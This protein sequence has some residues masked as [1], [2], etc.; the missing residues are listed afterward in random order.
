V[1][2]LLVLGAL[3][4][5]DG[6]Q[7]RSIS[8]RR[9]AEE[10]Y[11]QGLTQLEAGNYELA[12]AEFEEAMRYDSDL[13]DLQSRLQ[14]AKNMAG[15]QVTPTSETRQDAAALLYRQAVPHYESGNLAQA[16][17]ILEELRGLDADYQR[18][19]VKTMLLQAHRHLAQSAV[20]ENRLE[21]AVREFEAVL[22]LK[23]D[24]KET[25]DQLN[26]LDLY[27][28]ALQH[29]EGD[30]PSAIQALTDLYALAPDYKDV[31]A[32]LHN[33]HAFYA[34]EF[35]S[36]GDW[37]Q[38]AEEYGAAAEVF[39]LEATVDQRDDAAIQC[40]ATLEAPT[41][42]PALRVTP[43]PT[44]VSAAVAA[45]PIPRPTSV[46]GSGSKTSRGTGRIA[47]A[48]YD[49]VKQKH[50]LYILD[51]AQGGAQLVRNR[52]SQADF[53]P[54]GS[55]AGNAQGGTQRLVFRNH[56]PSHLGLGLLSPSTGEIVDLTAHVEDSNPAWSPDGQQILFAS[57]KHGDRKWRI[58]V[59]SP[60]AVRGE[61]EEW[62][63][64][65]MPAW[66]PDNTQVAYHGCDVRGDNCGVWIMKSGGFDPVRL[67]TDPS[68]TAPN[69]SPDGSQIAFISARSGNWE[70]YRV[71]MGTGEEFRLTDNPAVDVAPTWSP[72]GGQLAFLS[73]RG[74][75][76]AVHLLDLATGQVQKVIDTGDPYPEPLSQRL[77]WLP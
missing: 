24:D 71:S 74:G 5:Y 44:S 6:L 64:G 41:S 55:S 38:A 26:L 19:N 72:G 47:F 45:S 32:R 29:W 48:S 39:S 36:A 75:A 66:S 3:G 56:D 25:L 61:G 62:A 10:H 2:F 27:R 20:R 65:R 22:A 57:D 46:S 76:W 69:W 21:D 34:E 31:R 23:P 67:T 77:S 28:L 73:N 50:D 52:A 43:G 14:E 40:Q 7:D 58:Y 18:E 4:A 42:T 63:F 16:V 17:A 9:I 1:V 53:G 54:G 13:P 8:H 70:V 12:I 60:G 11:A 33:A 15:L 37:C 59:I 51:L 35:A 49:A 30:W 68:D